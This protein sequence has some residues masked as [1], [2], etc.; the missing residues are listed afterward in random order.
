[1]LISETRIR[2]L[3]RKALLEAAAQEDIDKRAV[4]IKPK[5]NTTPA[6]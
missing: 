5:A 4:E 3:V 1:M 2:S 6:E